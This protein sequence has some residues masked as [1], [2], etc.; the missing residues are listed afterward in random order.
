MRCLRLPLQ[1]ASQKAPLA[2]DDGTKKRVLVWLQGMLNVFAGLHLVF[3]VLPKA[4]KTL[5]ASRLFEWHSLAGRAGYLRT[6][7]L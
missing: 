5:E 7:T 2:A 1:F 6:R 3:L 4:A